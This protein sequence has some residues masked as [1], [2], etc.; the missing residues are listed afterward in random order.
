MKENVIDLRI[1][2][3]HKLLTMALTDLLCQKGRS[4]SSITINQICEQA[5]VHRTTFYKHFE[6][7]LDLLS[8]TMVQL[9][10]EYLQLSAEDRLK[11]PLQSL[12]KT[13]EGSVFEE[14]VQ[15][16][17]NDEMFNN[18][19]GKYIKDLI[20]QDFVELKKRGKSYALPIELIAEFHSG[21]VGSLVAWWS[22]QDREGISAE[23]LDKYYYQLINKEIFLK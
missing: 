16:Q 11:K 23:Q 4:F 20:K 13:T 17:K 9:M 19:L 2:R 7:K 5:M 10:Q 12:F 14:I 1:K 3:T 18:F 21:V 8:L 6:D 15:N 22:Y